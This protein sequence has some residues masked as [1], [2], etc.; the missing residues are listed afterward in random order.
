MHHLIPRG[1]GG[2]DVPDNIVPL[3]SACHGAVTSR[4]PG[5]LHAVVRS[6]TDAEYAYVIGKLG[7]GGTA[8][9]FG[10]TT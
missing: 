5:A 10:V 1:H 3:H 6:L 9:L 2:D 7:E 4:A 8:R